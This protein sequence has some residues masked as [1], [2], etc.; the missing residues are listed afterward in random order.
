MHFIGQ[1]ERASTSSSD[2]DRLFLGGLQVPVDVRVLRVLLELC[3]CQGSRIAVSQMLHLSHRLLDL[4][5]T[6][7]ILSF[8]F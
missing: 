3:C 4:A 5:F 1:L 6:Y 8:V 7:A 2:I